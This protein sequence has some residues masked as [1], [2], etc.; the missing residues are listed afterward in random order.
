MNNLMNNSTVK[1]WAAIAVAITLTISMLA[2]VSVQMTKVNL[3]ALRPIKWATV[4]VSKIK[5]SIGD[6]FKSEHPYPDEINQNYEEAQRENT[7]L[8]QQISTITQTNTLKCREILAETPSPQPAGAKK[9][10]AAPQTM[11]VSES[12]DIRQ[13]QNNPKYQECIL[14]GQNDPLIA[15]LQEKVAKFQTLYNARQKHDQ[16]VAKKL[17][18]FINQA[19]AAHAESNSYE[20]V[21]ARSNQDVIYNKTQTEADITGA[22]LGAMNNLN[23]KSM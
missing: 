20:L 13:I 6:K 2:M 14:A 3:S 5:Q 23:S 16:E 10:A 4:D 15:D 18:V 22:V 11:A 8:R 21:I 9:S 12:A 7:K 19:I 17:T 1:F